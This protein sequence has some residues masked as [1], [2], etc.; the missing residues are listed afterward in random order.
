MVVCVRC[1]R[2]EWFAEDPEELRRG[3]PVFGEEVSAL[4]AL[5]IGGG[6]PFRTPPQGSLTRLAQIAAS[7]ELPWDP[8]QWR[9]LLAT[10]GNTSRVLD[11]LRLLANKDESLGESEKARLVEA[12][13]KE[14][15]HGD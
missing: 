5:P 14:L 10:P 1:G 8:L 3:I 13:L 4:P 9:R 12:A 15:Q 2:T 6:S 7:L 11:M